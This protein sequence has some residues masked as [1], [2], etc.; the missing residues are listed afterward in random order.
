M[1]RRTTV[2]I[3]GMAALAGGCTVTPHHHEVRDYPDER[4]VIHE[5]DAYER[6]VI[7]ED[8]AYEGY[9]YVRIVYLGG[10]PWYVDEDLRARPVPP[11]LRSH[12][13][14]GAWSRSAPPSFGRDSGMRDGYRLSRI[15]YIDGIPH[16]VDEGRH[17]RPIPT[18]LRSRFAYES[19]ARHDD[20]RRPGE[21]AAPPFARVGNEARPLPPA[22]GRERQYPPLRE[23]DNAP[24]RGMP[25][26][27]M[28][29]EARPLPPTAAREREEPSTFGRG[30]ALGRVTERVREEARPLP[31]ATARERQQQ[32]VFETDG[33][34]RRGMPQ[35][36]MRADTSRQDPPFAD[37]GRV[38][39]E[40]RQPAEREQ[41]WDEPPQQGSGRR[42]RGQS[43]GDG[44]QRGVAAVDERK[45]DSAPGRKNGKGKGRDDEETD[46]R[47]ARDGDAG[48]RNRR[49]E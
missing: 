27:H 21:R 13:R 40:E 45:G 1:T 47:D 35:P 4:R 32:P 10:V 24:G 42:E 12:F 8:D 33:G 2:L 43:A 39:Q 37:R 29:E 15:V 6:H 31:P 3:L 44:R 41:G 28:R 17:A 49:D 18:R 48:R 34:P 7:Y 25:P 30:G 46:S 22:Y 9:Y 20:G 19:V 36:P 14:Y 23:A 5:D 38:R 11:H 26:G 16:H